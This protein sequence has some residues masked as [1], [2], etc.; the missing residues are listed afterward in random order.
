MRPWSDYLQEECVLQFLMGLNDSFAPLHAQIL[1]MEPFPNITK[2]FALAIR[3]ERQR[4]LSPNLL[5]SI[6]ES[7]SVQDLSAINAIQI[8]DDKTSGRFAHDQY[9]CTH[10]KIKGH[11]RERCFKLNGY[12]PNFKLRNRDRA[13]SNFGQVNQ[14]SAHVDQSNEIE[15]SS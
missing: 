12:P 11:S 4:V 9:Y 5:P 10:C 15:R 2:V 3:E 14:A 13:V 6:Q 1:T 7:T 8:S